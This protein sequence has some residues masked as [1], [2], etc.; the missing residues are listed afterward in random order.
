MGKYEHLIV[1]P[2][3]WEDRDLVFHSANGLSELGPLIS[4]LNREMV[5]G[6]DINIFV[7]HIEVK[8]DKGPDYVEVHTHDVSQAYVFPEAGLRFE[9]ILGEESYQAESPATVFIP[10][11]IK[12]NLKIIEGKGIEVCILRKGYYG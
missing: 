12:H 10:P 6:A 11:G 7:H 4:F 1:K 9:V 8:G 3:D 5:D 2:F